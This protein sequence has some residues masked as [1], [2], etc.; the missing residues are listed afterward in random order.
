VPHEVVLKT[1]NAS[2]AYLMLFDINQ[3]IT[4]IN[5]GFKSCSVLGRKSRVTRKSVLLEMRGFPE[6][7]TFELGIERV[8]AD[9]DTEARWRWGS[10][11]MAW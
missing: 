5:I 4:K 7:V 3:R 2:S 10:G 8:A 1:V 11:M 6:K 9:C